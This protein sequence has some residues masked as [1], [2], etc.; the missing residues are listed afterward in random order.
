MNSKQIPSSCDD[1]LAV[2]RGEMASLDTPPAVEQALLAAFARHQAAPS[3]RS[4]LAGVL[5]WRVLAPGGGVMAALLAA[6]VVLQPGAGPDAGAPPA[7][8]ANDA[9]IALQPVERIAQERAPRVVET[10]VP[11]I[12]L[13]ALG[14]AVTPQNADQTV[15]AEMLVA[16]D[17]QPLALRLPTL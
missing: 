13:A 14:I 2:L 12:A 3:W 1:A 16:T 17:G 9:F 15:R 5:T 6:L 10:E 11:R 4:R 7:M 8:A